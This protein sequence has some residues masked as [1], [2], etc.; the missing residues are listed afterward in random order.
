MVDAETWRPRLGFDTPKRIE[1]GAEDWGTPMA[2]G[3]EAKNGPDLDGRALAVRRAR[4]ASAPARPAPTRADDAAERDLWAEPWDDEPRSP[5]LRRA[6]GG[7]ARFVTGIV[8]VSIIAAAGFAA[9]SLL[10]Y[11]DRVDGFAPPALSLVA[12]ADAIAVLTGGSERIAAGGRLL[13]A[14]RAGRLLSGVNEAATERQVRGLL[15]VGPDLFE[16]C[17]TLDFDAL[18]TRGNARETAAWLG[19]V[20]TTDRP[21]RL[22][23]VTSNY[24]MERSL[25]ELSRAMPGVEMVPYP[26]RGVDL[27]AEGWWAD[28]PTIRVLTGEFVKL[29]LARALDLPLAGP[30]IAAALG[31]PGSAATPLPPEPVTPASTGDEPIGNADA[32][33]QSA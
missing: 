12:E 16:C 10:R 23:V 14:G 25:L 29:Q 1:A 13:E 21:P 9:G 19:D 2:F 4:E 8:L 31:L 11:L 33:G 26:V 5:L 22:I 18:D 6:V 32:G 30:R 17:V 24:H 28:A 15:G 20:P 3:R 27:D 7:T